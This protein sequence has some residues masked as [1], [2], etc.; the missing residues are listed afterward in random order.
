[1]Q[2]SS[3]PSARKL[4][5]S[6]TRLRDIRLPTFISQLTSR[7]TPQERTSRMKMKLKAK[8]RKRFIYPQIQAKARHFGS[9]GLRGLPEGADFNSIF[10]DHAKENAFV[11]KISGFKFNH[12]QKTGNSLTKT[13]LCIPFAVGML[14]P[15]GK[16]CPKNHS[17]RNAVKRDKSQQDD[18]AAV[19]TLFTDQYK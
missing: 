10:G 17:L 11:A 7:T 2:V 8:T 1:M 12:H 13:P 3:Q 5:L 15:K 19:D 16:S 14:C 4:K 18:V 9:L 6:S